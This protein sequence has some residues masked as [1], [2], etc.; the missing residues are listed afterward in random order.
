MENVILVLNYT[1]SFHPTLKSDKLLYRVIKK[2]P[3]T[4]K[5]LL[6]SNKV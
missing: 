4:L 6:L 2:E 3:N 1:E 5:S